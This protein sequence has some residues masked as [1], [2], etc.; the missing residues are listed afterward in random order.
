MEVE[1]FYDMATGDLSALISKPV[2]AAG[3]GLPYS[4]T[5]LK[6]EYGPSSEDGVCK[7]LGY[8]KAAKGSSRYSAV[9]TDTIQVNES[10]SIKGGP[11]T[12]SLTQ[13]VCLN[14]TNKPTTEKAVVLQSPS[15]QDSKL[16]FSSPALKPEYGPSSA[17]GVCKAL[18]FQ[19][20]AMGSA[21]TRNQDADTIQVN[22]EGKVIGGPKTWSLA[23]I[24][25]VNSN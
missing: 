17:D 16:P 9:D 23:Q 22:D 15:H 10:G 3:S 1:E 25:C 20:A 2:D 7:A 21:R 14:K 6:P 19:R 18:G 5:T 24:V 8:E 13:I 12:H 11:R 4:S